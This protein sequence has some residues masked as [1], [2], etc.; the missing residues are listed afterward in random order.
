MKRYAK[1]RNQAELSVIGPLEDVEEIGG[2]RLEKGQSVVCL[3]GSANRDFAIYRD[4]DR[5]DITRRLTRTRAPKSKKRSVGR[6]SIWIVRRSPS[7]SATRVFGQTCGATRRGF[8]QS[9]SYRSKGQSAAFVVRSA[10]DGCGNRAR[11][12]LREA[13]SARLLVS[14]T[15]SKHFRPWNIDQTLQSKLELDLL[16]LEQRL[17]SLFRLPARNEVQ[18][19]KS[20][21]NQ[22]QIV[23]VECRRGRQP[24][25]MKQEILYGLVLLRCFGRSSP[26][27]RRPGD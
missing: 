5:L 9:M 21:V 17:P 2:I 10:S 4:P 11:V 3:L 25:Q 16:G 22:F 24:T 15:M 12:E 7:G 8:W 13:C 26:P 6:A 14:V 27:L 23:R 1:L 18:L 20:S 19:L